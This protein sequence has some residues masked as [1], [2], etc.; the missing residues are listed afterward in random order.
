MNWKRE[1]YQ[2]LDLHGSL[3]SGSIT[4]E[5]KLG[6]ENAWVSWWPPK[7]KYNIKQWLITVVV[8]L[9][10]ITLILLIIIYHNY[11][12]S[13]Q[14]K[15]KQATFQYSCFDYLH[16]WVYSIKRNCFGYPWLWGFHVAHFRNNYHDFR[17]LWH[18][19]KTEQTFLFL[20]Q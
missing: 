14:Y 17:W 20:V 5:L 1:G 15:Y 3:I 13:Y 18:S 4:F 19:Y 16:H 8:T 6:V 12:Y 2:R 10:F 7:E 11:L 9:I